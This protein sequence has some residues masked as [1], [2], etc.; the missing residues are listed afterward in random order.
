MQN[1]I[2]IFS[3]LHNKSRCYLI[4]LICH[5]QPV[6]L[7]MWCGTFKFYELTHQLTHHRLT[8]VVKWN[9]KRWMSNFCLNLNHI[10]FELSKTFTGVTQAL[11]I[12][13]RFGENL[14]N[15]QSV[16]HLNYC[17]NCMWRLFFIYEFLAKLTFQMW[18]MN[19]KNFNQ[20]QSALI[21][22]L[23]IYHTLMHIY[24]KAEKFWICWDER[25]SLLLWARFKTVSWVTLGTKRPKL[26]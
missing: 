14:V 25:F 7:K 3:R 26:K 10:E 1:R 17:Y 4:N 22:V 19:V 12:L 18:P 15:R 9:V 13:K 24:W 5:C 11:A 23:S 20:V 21:F 8:N 16:R 2:Q 6:Y